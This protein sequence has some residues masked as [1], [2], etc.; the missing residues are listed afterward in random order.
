M[1]TPY[2]KD[3]ELFPAI[4][5][6]VAAARGTIPAVDGAH[7]GFGVT[8]YATCKYWPGIPAPVAMPAA[9]KSLTQHADDLEA[10]HKANSGVAA[11]TIDWGKWLGLISTIAAILKGLGV[12]A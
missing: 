1:A 11:H 6:V 2:L 5:Q 9:I 4:M 3:T 7:A 12:G 8:D 10:F